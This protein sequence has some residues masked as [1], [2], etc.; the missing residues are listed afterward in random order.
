MNV[1]VKEFLKAVNFGEDSLDRQEY[2]CLFDS[3]CKCIYRR[4]VQVITSCYAVVVGSVRSSVIVSDSRAWYG[5][6]G[7]VTYH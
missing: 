6:V 3:R 4:W 2:V 5:V 7:G 1:S